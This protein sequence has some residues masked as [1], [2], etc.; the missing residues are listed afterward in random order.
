MH[1]LCNA[2]LMEPEPRNVPQENKYLRAIIST[3][4]L[5]RYRMKVKEHK[6]FE[7]IVNV[8]CYLVAA[9]WF[10]KTR[11]SFYIYKTQ[12]VRALLQ[13]CNCKFNLC[14]NFWKFCGQ[15]LYWAL[16]LISS[17]TQKH[18]FFFLF[19]V[20]FI[21]LD[22]FVLNSQSVVHIC[23]RDVSLLLNIMELDGTWFVV[24]KTQ[25]NTLGKTQQQCLFPEIIWLSGLVW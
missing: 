18:I 19:V 3:E 11:L 8:F 9:E 14:S 4:A 7:W 12:W 5:D 24:L 20:L 13:M 21:H 16:W 15:F 2:L 6:V 1:C 22:C 17:Q 10:L 23:H 25:K